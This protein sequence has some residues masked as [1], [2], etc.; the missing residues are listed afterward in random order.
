MSWVKSNQSSEPS[1]DSAAIAIRALRRADAVAG[2]D[3]ECSV[4]RD[5]GTD[6][7][8]LE[9]GDGVLDRFVN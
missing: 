8:S 6:A 7:L 5:G 1:S 3:G 2:R 9:G 4:G